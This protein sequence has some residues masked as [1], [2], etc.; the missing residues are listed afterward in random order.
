ML[1]GQFSFLKR[2]PASLRVGVTH[3]AAVGRQLTGGATAKPDR[4]FVEEHTHVE[5][6]G[7]PLW[8]SKAHTV[9]NENLYGGH[10]NRAG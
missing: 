6:T 9:E 7:D 8:F 5:T 1:G 3:N 2:S 10:E 4:P